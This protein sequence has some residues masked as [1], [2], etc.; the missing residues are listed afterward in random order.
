M[1]YCE[2]SCEYR[3]D[4]ACWQMA[5]GVAEDNIAVWKVAL[6]SILDILLALLGYFALLGLGKTIGLILKHCKTSHNDCKSV[7]PIVWVE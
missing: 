2:N 7:G 6:H 5:S 3:R 4:S 1:V